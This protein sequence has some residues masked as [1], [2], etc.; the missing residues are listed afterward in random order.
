MFYFF[1]NEH[2]ELANFRVKHVLDKLQMSLTY[3]KNDQPY[4]SEIPK[5]KMEFGWQ[6]SA[7][8]KEGISNN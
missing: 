3:W 1:L 2:L 8:L 6:I 7:Q 4:S 5:G